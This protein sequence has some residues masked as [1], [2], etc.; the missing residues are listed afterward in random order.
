MEIVS[1]GPLLTAHLLSE[2]DTSVICLMVILCLQLFLLQIC[3]A[4]Q[5]QRLKHSVNMLLIYN[6]IVMPVLGTVFD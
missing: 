3:L 1:R 2:F 5:G 6:Y 4:P